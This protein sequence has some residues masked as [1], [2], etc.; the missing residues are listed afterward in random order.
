MTGAGFQVLM[1]LIGLRPEG[2][3]HDVM[4]LIEIV[5]ILGNSYR[6][7]SGGAGI[8]GVYGRFGL[9]ACKLAMSRAGSVLH[10]NDIQ[11]IDIAR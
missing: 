3:G 11:D 1:P 5:R 6:L 9:W 2:V 4:E 10:P 7:A 8:G